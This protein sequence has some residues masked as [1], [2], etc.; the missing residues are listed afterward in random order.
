MQDKLGIY[1]YI[2][3]TT[4]TA[5]IMDVTKKLQADGI[6][7]TY[8]SK[9]D[10]A[11][12]LNTK[13]PRIAQTLSTYKIANPLPATL[14]IRISSMDDYARVAQII[15]AYKS[16]FT[17]SSIADTSLGTKAQEQR[18]VHAL[19]VGYFLRGFVYA[20]IV[21]FVM[22]V[23]TGYLYTIHYKIAHS[24]DTID[25]KKYLGASYA[26]IRH[27]YYVLAGIL[28]AGGTIL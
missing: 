1:L 27:P 12:K 6:T 20:L 17:D 19:D 9:D 21:L 24:A 26:Q 22:I 4:S 3:D 5:Q 11:K 14:S 15:P 16:L 23:V 2:K 10:A 8:F 7:S 13:I 18:I 25:V 28:L